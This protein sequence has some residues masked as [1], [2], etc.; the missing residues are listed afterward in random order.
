MMI[1]KILLIYIFYCPFVLHAQVFKNKLV[2]FRHPN[3]QVLAYATA[4]GVD[5]AQLNS[6]D[7]N[8]DGILDLFIF[9][10]AGDVIMPFL[11]NSST[12]SYVYAPEYKRQFPVL[13][14]WVLAE[15]YN[16]DGIQDLFASSFN[17]EGI[18]GIELYKGT[19][20]PSGV[21][22][23][24]FDMGK[25]FK[26]LYFSFG[27]GDAQIPIDF[28]DLPAIDDVD[29]DGDLDII[30]FEP[31]NNRVSLFK[32]VV[33]ERGYSKDTLA[34]VLADRCYGRFAESGFT[35][36]IELSTHPDTCVSQFKAGNTT[37]H[38]G[39]TLLSLDL[40][41]NHLQD[42]L[43]GDLSN[44]GIIALYNEGSRDNAFMASQDTQWPGLA[45]QVNLAIFNA[46]FKID[47]D[48]DQQTDLVIAPNQRS[49]SENINNI[50]F[51]KNIG[52]SSKP[53]FQLETKSL[54]VD[55]MIDLGAGSD[56]CFV[57]VNQDGLIDL[58]VGTEG[59]FIK[60]TNIRDARLVFFQNIG[61][62]NRPVFQLVD[63]NYLNF[64]QFALSQDA[65][66]SFTPAFGDLDQDGDLDLLVGENQGQFFYCENT[67][68]PGQAFQFKK[69]VYPYFDLSAKSFSSP[70]LIDLNQD[71]LTDIV[72]GSR[73][74]TNDVNNMACGSFYYFQNQGTTGNSIFDP[75]YLKSP[76]T[77]CLGKII[78]PA[79]TSK[80]YTCPE[81]Y[82]FGNSIKLFTGN[83]FG[84][85][86][87]I[88]GISSNITDSY[89][90][91]NT[92]FGRIKEGERLTLSLADIDDD[93]I[94]DMI[95][96]NA[97][98]G[99][100]FY[101]TNLRTDGTT[102]IE[103]TKLQDV[104]IYPNP[105]Q[106]KLNIGNRSNK[107]L[108]LSLMDVQGLKMNDYIVNQDSHFI[109]DLE[110]LISGVYFIV[111][112]DGKRNICF[113]LLKQ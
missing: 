37:R 26:A 22:Y 36:E 1:M 35:S 94:L 27:N 68:G 25:S 61:T 28:T 53:E 7:L 42:L 93:G 57:D 47:L 66:F 52:S 73:Q 81:F 108:H 87:M 74:N 78:V 62:S 100:A 89:Q 48:K 15:D 8:D 11:Y 98:G 113:K 32:N 59:F 10:R 101:E 65:H 103:E 50:W 80:S 23:I 96:G 71:G 106:S 86:K 104:S 31:G 102:S 6:I 34:F 58:I 4:G 75:D 105:V 60:G 43:V 16:K 82:N 56:P 111:L 46:A 99:I 107:L 77:N 76:N 64:N 70:F 83:I 2:E 14:D 51:Y 33:K 24:K 3:S 13:K 38:S 45:N 84:E 54:F 17:T 90:F 69:P 79:I 67:A 21:E 92:N 44:E 18:P 95:T 30:L 12:A 39:S 19:R 20:G 29:G 112:N 5:N 97:R 109:L 85:A 55:Q 40:D 88:G 9:D 110:Y 49:I 41:G 91:E 63:S 72:S